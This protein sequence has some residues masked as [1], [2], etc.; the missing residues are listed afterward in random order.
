MIPL[1]IRG[2]GPGGAGEARTGLAG[3]P[4]PTGR[5]NGGFAL[6]DQRTE[7]QAL[8]DRR[9]SAGMAEKRRNGRKA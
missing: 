8:R 9:I 1:A 4:V 7:I 6:L 5:N 2:L 3:S